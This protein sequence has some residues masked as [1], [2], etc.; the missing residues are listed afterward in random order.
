MD[1]ANRLEAIDIIESGSDS[2]VV[3]FVR[4]GKRGPIKIGMAR[5]AGRRVAGLS[6]GSPKRLEV[7]GTTLGGLRM[8]RF[9]HKLFASSRLHGEW[10]R[11]SRELRRWIT[12]LCP[13]GFDS[14]T[15][16]PT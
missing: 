4:A 7:I 11:P 2:R 15:G 3:Y 8:E 6:S 16:E 5:H 14:I 12:M 13:K 1:E 9:L 10:F